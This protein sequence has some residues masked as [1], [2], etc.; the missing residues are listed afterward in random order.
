MTSD[1]SNKPLLS[2]SNLSKQVT[3][4]DGSQ[5]NILRN[6]N[7]AVHLGET[8]AITGRSGSG[9]TT[10]LSLMAGLD[11]DYTGNLQLRGEELSKIDEDK[12]AAL[13]MGAIGFVFQSF[14]LLPSMTALENVALPMEVAGAAHS[15]QQAEDWLE[16]L[17]MGARLHQFP[18]QLSGGGAATRR[19]RSGHGQSARIGVCR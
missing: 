13:R 9:K 14:H 8:V 3:L 17:G 6:L 11:A 7:L 2:A 4:H 1:S 16:Q 18:T 19:H 12:R 5:L 15:L 10:L